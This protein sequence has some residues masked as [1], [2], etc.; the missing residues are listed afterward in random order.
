[1]ADVTTAA[2]RP[3]TIRRTGP[4]PPGTGGA[5][6]RHHRTRAPPTAPAAERTCA[7]AKEADMA[8]RCPALPRVARRPVLQPGHGV[9]FP[10]VGRRDG[11]RHRDRRVGG[12]D[13]PRADARVL[14]S[15][16]ARV[17]GRRAAVAEL[18]RSLPDRDNWGVNLIH[19]PAEPGHEER[20]V[21]LLVRAA[22]PKVSASA[23]ME[24]TPASYAARSPGCAD[25]TA[26]SP[27]PAAVRQGLPPR[28]R[29]EVPVPGAAEILRRLLERG[30]ITR[31]EADLAARCRSP[32]T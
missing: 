15:R 23:Y 14:R 7:P 32:R 25:R 3:S 20:L 27:R 9:R 4:R 16:R 30:Q 6:H 10:Y 13:G 19:S 1:V 29:R 2:K 26:A 8:A 31:D 21:D 24:L 11:Q 22:V 17:A 12:G 18:R 5:G 28:G